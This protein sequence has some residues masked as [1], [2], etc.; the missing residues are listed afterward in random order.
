[1][2][3]ILAIET[4]TNICS[5]ALLSNNKI[6]AYKENSEHN[7]H[8]QSLTVL[9]KKLLEESD[10]NINKIDAF[11]VSI[12]PGSYT[13]L[14]IGVSVTKGL[15]FGLSKP[16]IAVSTLKALAKQFLNKNSKKN[17]SN[18]LLCPMLDAR[19]LEVYTALYK[20][21]LTEI[22]QPQPLLIDETSFKKQLLK[23]KICFFGD[24]SEKC[25]NI[26][27]SENA[28]FDCSINISA[29]AVAQIAQIMFDGKQ[30]ADVA[31]FEP[32]YLKEFIAIKSTKKLF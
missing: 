5:I 22:I 31:Y 10:F 6:I 9:I 16:V 30:F 3:H 14:R 15:C 7:S 24:G 19:R 17:N 2:S 11:A 23:N 28:I 20:H 21:D 32:L 12:G 25:K 27:N 18:L 1:M 26:I 13:G 29:I 4:S 8:S